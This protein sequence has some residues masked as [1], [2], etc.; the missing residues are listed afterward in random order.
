MADT[1]VEG[2]GSRFHSVEDGVFAYQT[3]ARRYGGFGVCAVGRADYGDAQVGFDGV[4]EA[5]AVAHRGA[6]FEG[7]QADV[8]FVFAAG[9]VAADF[10]GFEISMRS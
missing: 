7:A 9:G 5:E 6:V 10:C 4:G 1:A 8:E 2:Y 3:R